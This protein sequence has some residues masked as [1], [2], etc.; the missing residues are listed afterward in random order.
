MLIQPAG[1]APGRMEGLILLTFFVNTKSHT[2]IQKVTPA[3]YE[4]IYIE[5][6]NK[7]NQF[8]KPVAFAARFLSHCA[9]ARLSCAFAVGSGAEQRNGI[10]LTR[11]VWP[12]DPEG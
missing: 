11:P 12:G 6:T 5:S 1:G 3:W 2:V 8:N 7:R 9:R 10:G 4:H